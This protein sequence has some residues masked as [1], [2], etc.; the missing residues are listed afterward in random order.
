MHTKR[1]SAVIRRLLEHFSDDATAV[2]DRKR[3]RS[4]D[5][6]D[7]LTRWC[8]NDRIRATRDFKLLRGR[9]ELASFHD[10]PDD[11][12]IAEE[13]LPFVERLAAEKLIRYEAPPTI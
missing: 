11:I 9:V 10:T 6:P 3:F 2:I 5:F 4:S 12:W 13:A 7:L 1:H 8:T